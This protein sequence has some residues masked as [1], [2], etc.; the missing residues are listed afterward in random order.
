M[1]EIVEL[2]IC[3]ICDDSFQDLEEHF[4]DKHTTW[5]IYKCDTCNKDYNS[6]KEL[7]KHINAIHTLSFE[8]KE[9]VTDYQNKECILEDKTCKII[10]GI[11]KK[12]QKE[13][14][15]EN[16]VITI[17]DSSPKKSDLQIEG[18]KEHK[19]DSCGK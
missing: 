3:Y 7:E 1:A 2:E 5:K 12:Q 16:E 18:H 9:N 15:I 8:I 6:D 4:Y 10:S 14:I 11:N 19:C 13:N 17:N